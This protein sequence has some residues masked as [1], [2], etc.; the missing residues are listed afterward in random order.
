MVHEVPS[1]HP[2]SSQLTTDILF[3]AVSRFGKGLTL[4]AKVRGAADTSALKAF[5]TSRFNQLEF[6]GEHSGT[7]Q[8]VVYDAVPWSQIFAL[9]ENAKRELDLE[10]YS[11]CQ[12]TLEQVFLDFAQHQFEEKP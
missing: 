5:I 8:Y 12:S 6:K 3:D 9:M 11:I 4:M 1:F 10:D 7:V 2:F